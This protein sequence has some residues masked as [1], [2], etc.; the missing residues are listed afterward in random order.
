MWRT[1]P[2]VPRRPSC[3]RPERLTHCIVQLRSLVPPLP[4]SYRQTIRCLRK[5]SGP[6]T[7]PKV[8]LCLLAA[9]LLSTTAA[10]QCIVDN[11]AGSKANLNRPQDPDV[12]AAK[13][14]PLAAVNASLPG[15]LCFTAGYRIRYEGYSAGSFREGNSDY[16]LLTR[17]RLGALFKP[18]PWL[19]SFVELQDATAFWKSPPVGP[20]YQSTWDLRRAYI[21]FGDLEKGPA[22]LRIGRQDI[23][24]GHLRLV[25]TAYWRNASRGYDAVM[26]VANQDAFRVNAW[27]ASPVMAVDNGL[28][29]HQ[30]GNNFHGVYTA[31]KKAI[32]DSVLEPYVL[33]R[34]TPGFKTE[35]GRPGKLDEKTFGVRWAGNASRFDYDA[36]TAAQAGHISEDRIRAWAWSAILGYTFESARLKPRVFA[37]YDFASGD[38]NPQDGLRGTFDQLYPNIHDHH[39]LA[40]QVAWQNLKSIRAGVRTSLRPNW[41]LA[42][43]YNDWWLAS[44]KDA[45]YGGTGAV[46][47]RDASGLSGTHI[48]REYDVQTSYRPNRHLELGTGLGYIRSG[49]FLVRTN[50]SRSYVY[51]Y[52]MLYYNV[53]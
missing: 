46:V 31:L 29:H 53:N 19:K 13:F 28:S 8:W 41:M 2:T 33:W 22:S 18:A 14:S 27:V 40:D 49:A 38:R 34:L 35:A 45:F 1:P 20:P 48:G 26:F 7:A 39:G 50:H 3:R 36:E 12:P 21:D 30:Q 17:F 10:A 51:P 5:T 23:A 9:L 44:P 43:A 16:Y 25:G 47:A 6:S 52:V 32:P 37:K 4:S 15:W 11:P 42:G 24:F